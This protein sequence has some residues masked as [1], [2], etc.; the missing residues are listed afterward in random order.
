MSRAGKII[1][2]KDKDAL[3]NS[4]DV[5]SF[6]YVTPPL[7]LG[8]LDGL[9]SLGTLGAL[10]ALIASG[11]PRRLWA[12]VALMALMTLIALGTARRLLSLDSP[13]QDKKN[14]GRIKLNKE[15]YKKPTTVGDFL[16]PLFPIRNVSHIV[17]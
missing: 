7:S 1:Q 15:Q 4:F 2:E 13:L 6:G 5:V 8:S 16:F 14:K 9:D 10:I 11:M 3:G 12:L 17:Q